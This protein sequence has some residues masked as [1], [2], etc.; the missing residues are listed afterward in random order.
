[1]NKFI[2]Y[3]KKGVEIK[4]DLIDNGRNSIELF[5]N[6]L[7]KAFYQFKNFKI[8]NKK[9]RQIKAIKE[10]SQRLIDAIKNGANELEIQAILADLREVATNPDFQ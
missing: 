9:Q 10:D 1:M 4:I 7:A 3:I 2:N 5:I 6:F 8:M